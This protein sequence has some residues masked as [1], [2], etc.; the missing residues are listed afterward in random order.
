MQSQNKN[1][2]TRQIKIIKGYIANYEIWP[3][4][5]LVER[6]LASP[7]FYNL[8]EDPGFEKSGNTGL[9]SSFKGSDLW[10]SSPIINK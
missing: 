4:N 2:N 9:C 8:P 5:F 10:L 3:L 7:A 6:Y 1:G